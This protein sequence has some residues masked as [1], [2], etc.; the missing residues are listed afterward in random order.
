MARPPRIQFPGA[1]YHVIVR[2][3]QQQTIFN[4]NKDRIKYLDLLEHYKKQHGF[5]KKKKKKKKGD[6]DELVDLLNGV[7]TV[8][9]LS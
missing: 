1:F 8:G 9:S 3:N 4:D 7:S 6:V 2:G 5:K